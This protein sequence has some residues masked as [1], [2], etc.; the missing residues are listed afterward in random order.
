MCMRCMHHQC[1]CWDHAVSTMG[2][3]RAS[4]QIQSNFVMLATR[5]YPPLAAGQ[6]MQAAH[7]TRRVPLASCSGLSGCHPCE[8]AWLSCA[9]LRAQMAAMT[10]DSKLPAVFGRGQPASSCVPGGMHGTVDKAQGC[11]VGAHREACGANEVVRPKN[12]SASRKSE[13]LP[14]VA[15]IMAESVH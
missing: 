9:L 5:S 1:F 15:G 13:R 12:I 11:S 4:D 10:P 14:G 3:G 6:M 7:Q 8:L 2:E